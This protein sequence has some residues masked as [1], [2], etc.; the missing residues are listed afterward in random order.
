MT[1]VDK[2][3]T[4]FNTLFA[5]SLSEGER[6]AAFFRSPQAPNA[7]AIKITIHKPKD[8]NP[9]ANPPF[10]VNIWGGRDFEFSTTSAGGVR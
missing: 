1:P 5:D 8:H 7:S 2:A 3:Q 6:V 4:F 10:A 9:S